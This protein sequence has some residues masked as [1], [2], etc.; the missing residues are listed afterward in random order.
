[1]AKVDSYIFAAG[2]RY[3][4]SPSV[5]VQAVAKDV[6]RETG[7]FPPLDDLTRL[8]ACPACGDDRTLVQETEDQLTCRT[9]GRHYARR[10]GIWDFKEPVG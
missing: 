1:L 6:S 7:S 5:F 8:F 4:L 3:P 9:C 2:G 10:D